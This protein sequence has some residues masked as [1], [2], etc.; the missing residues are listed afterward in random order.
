MKSRSAIAA[1]VAAAVLLLAV[2]AFF[3]FR[4]CPSPIVDSHI[5]APGQIV[6]VH[7]ANQPFSAEFARV[8]I[9]L[10]GGTESKWLESNGH[11]PALILP[12]NHQHYDGQTQKLLAQH[13]EEIAKLQKPCMLVLDAKGNVANRVNVSP[14]ATAKEILELSR[15]AV[16][17]APEPVNA[18]TPDDEVFGSGAVFVDCEFSEQPEFIK[19]DTTEEVTFGAFAA[20]KEGDEPF[21]E[22]AVSLIPQSE[23]NGLIAKIDEA[24]GGLDLLVTRIYD[25]KQEGSCTWNAASQSTEITEAMMFG[26]R[27]V[28]HKSAISGYKR[29]G[30]GPMS[31]STVSCSL[32]ELC[33]RGVLPLDTPENRAKFAHVMPNTGFY[34]SFPQGW[35]ET[36]KRFRVQDFYEIRTYEG[37]IT[38]LLRGSP[39]VYGRSGHAICAVRPVIKDGRIYVKYANSWHESWGDKGFGYDSE[40]M[41]RSGASWAYAPKAMFDSAPSVARVQREANSRIAEPVLT[42]AP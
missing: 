11:K 33:T 36:A 29:C 9:G 12:D 42:M 16:S 20:A 8:G 6:L 1:G 19:G 35:E 40:R 7:P 22:D 28:V 17:R 2:A 18:S 31:G 10:Q 15:L 3:C 30:S 23:W 13:A 32:K 37:F 38:A 5:E 27:N 25:Q 34:Q 4:G 41:I 21:F 14:T 26:R 39:V 24:G